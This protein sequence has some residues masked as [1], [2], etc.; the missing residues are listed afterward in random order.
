MKVESPQFVVVSSD[1]RGCSDAAAVVTFL[2][3]QTALTVFTKQNHSV[4]LLFFPL[5]LPLS[6]TLL[7]HEMIVFF[8]SFT[9]ILSSFLHPLPSPSFHF[10]IFLC[11]FACYLSAPPF[12]ACKPNHSAEGGASGQS[13]P[14]HVGSLGQTEDQSCPAKRRRASGPSKVNPDVGSLFSPDS[15]HIDVWLRN[16]PRQ[17]CCLG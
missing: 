4:A 10:L 11:F 17:K 14:P 6:A 7:L 12:Q 13:L 15:L 2:S 5:F 1:R 16:P 8:R 9:P 3:A